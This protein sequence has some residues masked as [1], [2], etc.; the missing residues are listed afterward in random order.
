[1]GG[2]KGWYCA[3]FLWKIRGVIDQIIG[4][5]G[6]KR[7]RHHPMQFRIG[8]VIDWWRV[9]AVEMPF[10]LTLEAEIKLPGRAWLQFEITKKEPGSEICQTVLFDPIGITGLLYWYLLYFPHQMI[11][12]GMNKETAKAA[13]KLDH[14][15]DTKPEKDKETKVNF[16]IK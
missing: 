8:D 15:D 7:G 10:K 6:M 5:V 11:F 9:V 4:G 3:N 16:F 2:K 13:E 14:I 1:M 12:R